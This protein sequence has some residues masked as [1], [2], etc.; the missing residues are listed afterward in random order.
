MEAAIVAAFQAADVFGLSRAPV[1]DGRIAGHVAFSRVSIEHGTG[2]WC[3]LGP[4]AVAPDRQGEDIGTALV[5]EGLGRLGNLGASGCG[6]LGDP[7]CYGRFGF[8]SDGRISHGDIPM[9]H[10]QRIVLAGAPAARRGLQPPRLP[11][12]G[13]IALWPGRR[14]KPPVPSITAVPQSRRNLTGMAPVDSVDKGKAGPSA[15]FVPLRRSQTT[16]RPPIAAR[17]GFVD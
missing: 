14:S 6:V 17:R 2:T 8:E 9:R 3:G 16:D 11:G 10:L 13:H 12:D 7:G 1:A 15:P 4:L 5:R